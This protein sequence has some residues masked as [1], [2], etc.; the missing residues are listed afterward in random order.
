MERAIILF[1]G[2]A[3]AGCGSRGGGEDATDTAVDEQDSIPDGEVDEV[4]SGCSA[5]GD[6]D[7]SDPCTGDEC[8]T[9]T[10]ECL[11]P[12]LD[13][14]E[15]GYF[16]AIGLD[17][18]T[19]CDGT[20]CDDSDD[21]VYPGSATRRC[22]ED[23]DCSGR[24]DADNDGDGHARGECGGDD[25]DDERAERF[26]G[27]VP[28]CGTDLS[29]PM[30]DLDCSG[31]VD[32]DDD[33]DS[34]VDDACGGDDCDDSDPS[35]HPGA[36]EVCE[37][38]VDG[39]CDTLADTPVAMLDDV[40]VTNAAGISSHVQIVWSGSEYALAWHDLRHGDAEA[41]FARISPDGT[42]VGSDV[43]VSNAEGASQ[44]ASI[45]W[46]GSRYGVAWQDDRT[47]WSEVHMSVLSPAG[48]LVSPD[49]QVTSGS[50]NQ[51]F[52]PSIAW[53]GSEFAMAMHRW[54][55][56]TDAE[57][58]LA[59]VAGD[60]ASVL[61]EVQVTTAAYE[62]IYPSL[63]WNGSSFGIFWHD[64]RDTGSLGNKEIYF[65]SMS[66]AGTT[67]VS[68]TR[69]TSDPQQSYYADQAWNGSEWGVVWGDMETGTD[70]I[71][72]KR[73]SE[74]GDEIGSRL[75]VTVSS[76]G[77]KL[78]AI[79][80]T[81]SEYGVA[82]QTYGSSWLESDIFFARIGSDAVPVGPT[83]RITSVASYKLEVGIAWSGSEW[84][85]AWEDGRSS[86]NL[87]VYFNRIGLCE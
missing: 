22:G 29:D 81:G 72:M 69:L 80:W 74:S 31:T 85:V 4:E 59:R 18:T 56:W 33:S 43:R 78:P 47:A 20:D 82:W 40:R 58:H 86:G 32:S 84:G 14:D 34:S 46:T 21:E 87:E 60:G 83:A 76:A 45:V 16:A 25:C 41:Y 62:S 54:I 10:G 38:W 26:P 23:G 8:D 24:P 79:V 37:D 5:D 75:A 71:Y 19:A 39:D 63:R 77:S 27:A 67:L 73:V 17:G 12:D 6:C 68:D 57:I 35:I 7:D 70:E 2:L 36:T 28:G 9:T 42:L 44:N 51:S 55:V 52:S 61:G 64:N 15:D 30:S 1:A 65:A 53:T 3:L 49:L 48:A 13:V 66:A 50:T 11:H